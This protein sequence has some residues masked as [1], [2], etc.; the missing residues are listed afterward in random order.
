MA[1]TA[2]ETRVEPVRRHPFTPEQYLKLAELGIFKGRTE[3]RDGDILL[4]SP[5]SPRHNALILR[6]RRKL[7]AILG[8]S[9]LVFEQSTVR[10]G[11]WLPEP[12]VLVAFPRADDYAESYPAPEEIALVIEVSVSTLA[13]DRNEKLPRYAA[14]GV[15]ELWLYDAEARAFEV[16]REPS[17]NAYRSK[18]TFHHD[19][20]FALLAFAQ[21]VAN[22]SPEETTG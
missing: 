1:L 15:K 14:A 5:T 7:E 21:Q 12:D 20:A 9:V 17:G 8:A 22:W 11:A 10:F 6:L 19:E 13:D 3:L 18:Q 4:M 2:P 16:Y